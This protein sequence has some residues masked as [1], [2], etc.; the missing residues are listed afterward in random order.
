MVGGEEVLGGLESVR[1]GCGRITAAGGGCGR[2][3]GRQELAAA[4]PHLDL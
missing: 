1:Q 3:T 4:F 2:T